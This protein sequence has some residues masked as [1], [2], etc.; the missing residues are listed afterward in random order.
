MDRKVKQDT[1]LLAD[2][3]S[4][5]FQARRVLGDHLA[6]LEWEKEVKMGSRVSQ[7]SKVIGVSQEK[8]DRQALQ[9]PKVLLGSEE[10]RELGSQ[11]PLEHRASQVFQEKKAAQGLQVLQGLRGLLALEIQ[12]CQA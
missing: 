2:Q 7:V 3:V 4:G 5:A 12:A 11:E 6:L 8:G 10:H 1:V 9:D